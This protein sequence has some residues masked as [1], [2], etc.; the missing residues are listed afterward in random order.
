MPGP[1]RPQIG[2]AGAAS[3]GEIEAALSAVDGLAQCLV[4]AREDRPGDVRLVGYVV[5]RAG[6]R[7]E[8]DALKDILKRTLPEYMVPQHLV[9]LGEIPLLPNGKVDRKALPAP[10]AIP[11]G[12]D[13][14]APRDGL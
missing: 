3:P 14:A 5:P 13:F 11:T 8:E 2:S 6:A 10:Q 12:R 9:A 4:V 7:L 1:H